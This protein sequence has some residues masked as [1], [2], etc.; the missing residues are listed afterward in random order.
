MIEAQSSGQKYIPIL[1]PKDRW[2]K[3]ILC[4]LLIGNISFTDSAIALSKKT[5]NGTKDTSNTVKIKEIKSS[6]GYLI[7]DTIPSGMEVYLSGKY[8]GKTPIKRLKVDSGTH[9][10]GFKD[11]KKVYRP[12]SQDI[13]VK[14]FDVR[15]I[16]FQMMKDSP[17]L[18]MLGEN[19]GRVLVN[20]YLTKFIVPGL[21]LVPVGEVLI[22][23]IG[24]NKG[25]SH[26][27]NLKKGQEL[28]VEYTLTRENAID[29]RGDTIRSLDMI[30]IPSGSFTMGSPKSETRSDKDE[31]PLHKVKIAKSFFMGKYEVTQKQYKMIMGVNPSKFLGDSLPVDSVSWVDIQ[32]FMINLNQRVGCSKPD[33][34]RLVDSSGLS[35]IPRGCFRLPTEAEWEYAARAGTKT[36]FSFGNSLDSSKAKFNSAQPYGGGSKGVAQETTFAVGSFN[37]NKFGLYDMHGNVVEW[38]H[39]WY[40]SES[41]IKSFYRG[42]ANSDPVNTKKAYKRVVRGGGWAS[43]GRYLRAANRS[44]LTQDYRANTHG[45]RLVAV[46]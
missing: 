24:R 46:Q 4:L 8:K 29:L 37:P 31:R 35:A 32:K 1:L 6:Y 27:F 2:M 18:L 11:T 22:E 42:S 7:I 38:C 30:K 26:K 9:K 45:F 19:R 16:N 40:D 23:I 12:F 10:L 15:S 43:N 13:E 41:Y 44:K 25:F 21:V 39:D 3:Y 5:L 36:A 34:L 28:E 33:T 20:G 17:K 14:K